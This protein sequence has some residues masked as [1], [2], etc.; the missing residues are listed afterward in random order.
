MIRIIVC[1][2]LALAACATPSAYHARAEDQTGYAERQLSA[3][4]WSV[5]YRGDRFDSADAVER[6]MLRRAAE[7]TLQNG[8]DWFSQRDAMVESEIVVE[9]RAPQASIAA[10]WRPRWRRQSR[11]EWTD[12]DPRGAQ[13]TD[14]APP[15]PP[16]SER[17]SAQAEIVMGRAPAPPGAFDARAV[18][19]PM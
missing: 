8:Y 10:V 4:A 5:E 3:E 18:L 19:A 6:H 1:A 2:A 15:P 12:W 16:A 17:F 13:P 7:L 11:F 9:A 14:R